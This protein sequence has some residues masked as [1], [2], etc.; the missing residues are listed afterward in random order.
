[1]NIFVEKDTSKLKNIILNST[2]NILIIYGVTILLQFF[3][4]INP[5]SIYFETKL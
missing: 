2:S 1:M 3:A 5:L 4:I